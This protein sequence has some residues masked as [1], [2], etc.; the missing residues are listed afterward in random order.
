MKEG[1]G[2]LGSPFNPPLLYNLRFNVYVYI[3]FNI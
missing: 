1:K 3:F 2:E